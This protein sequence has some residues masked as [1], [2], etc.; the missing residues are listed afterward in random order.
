MTFVVCGESRLGK[1][2]CHQLGVQT[3]TWDKQI[4]RRKTVSDNS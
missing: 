1:A 4:E 2:R 3:A